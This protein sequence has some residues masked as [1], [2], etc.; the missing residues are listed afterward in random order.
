M[1]KTL[2]VA[3]FLSTPRNIRLQE[4]RTRTSMVGDR[5]IWTGFSIGRHMVIGF[6]AQTGRCFIL[7]IHV[8]SMV[9][10][11]QNYTRTYASTN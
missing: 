11:E 2:S 7:T 1:E 6:I 8:T 9:V 4:E 10:P 5:K 3:V